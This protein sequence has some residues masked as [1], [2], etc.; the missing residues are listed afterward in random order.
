MDLDEKEYRVLRALHLKGPD[1]YLET[2]KW[3]TKELCY[4]FEMGKIIPSSILVNDWYAY[5]YT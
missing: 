5:L 3:L 1:S 4:Q 2:E